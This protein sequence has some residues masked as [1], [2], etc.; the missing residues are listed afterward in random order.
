M[1]RPADLVEQATAMGATFEL[2]TN[3]VKVS[4]REG[5]LPS[6]LL[7]ELRKHKDEIRREL[8]RCQCEDVYSHPDQR[9]YEL[10]ELVRRV[11]EEG[12]ELLWSNVLNDLVAFHRDDV[13][14]AEIPAGFVP[15]SD[16][17]LRYMFGND[18]ARLLPGT[19]RLIHATNRAGTSTMD[20]AEDE[21][22]AAEDEHHRI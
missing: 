21:G 13:D 8:A 2:T 15:Y 9:D 6:D 18:G 20:S 19:L 11:E 14:P 7:E 3:G 5:P 12:Y 17:E 10:M 22:R 4:R 1:N 16:D